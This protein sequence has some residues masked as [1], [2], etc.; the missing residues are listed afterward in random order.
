MRLRPLALLA[1]AVLACGSP[2]VADGADDPEEPRPSRRRQPPRAS[3]P[4]ETPE[5]PVIYLVSRTN[6]LL[7]F[8]PVDRAFVEVGPVSCPDEHSSP[9]A[10]SVDRSGRAWVLYASGELYWVSTLDASCA[11]SPWKPGAGGFFRFGMG[12]V[13]DADGGEGLYISGSAN[14]KLGRIDP[15]TA[16]V[17][18]IGALPEGETNPELAGG[19]APALFAWFPGDGE[20]FVAQLDRASGEAVRRWPVPPLEGEA[21]AWA[22]ASLGGQVYLFVTADEAGGSRSRVWQFDPPSGEVR[23]AVSYAP[24]AIVGAGV[25][26]RAPVVVR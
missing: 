18:A 11:R 24:Y 13:R 7:L 21:T 4:S 23:L 12:F 9:T 22:A 2:P 5:V 17:T 8:D 1:L 3:R 14:G 26:T 16:G 10:M 19:D 20:A 6:R 15:V 25:G